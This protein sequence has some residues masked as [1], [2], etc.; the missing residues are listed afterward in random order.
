M[1]ENLRKKNFLAFII[2]CVLLR[3]K[4]YFLTK[5]A[6]ARLRPSGITHKINKLTSITATLSPSYFNPIWNRTNSS[7]SIMLALLHFDNYVKYPPHNFPS[8]FAN[9]LKVPENLLEFVTSEHSDITALL[10]SVVYV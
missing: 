6:A 9:S 7:S 3:V 8:H 10:L 5:M 1:S 2:E 4:N